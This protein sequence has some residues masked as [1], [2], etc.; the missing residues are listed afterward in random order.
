MNAVSAERAE[1]IAYDWD[2]NGAEIAD[3]APRKLHGVPD[4][5]R[6]DPRKLGNLA[7]QAIIR[8]GPFTR[9]A[10]SRHGTAPSR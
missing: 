2:W 10:E 1:H 7:A 3:E 4:K 6:V 5:E 8:L 9:T